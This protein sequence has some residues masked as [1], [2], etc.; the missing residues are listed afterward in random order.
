MIKRDIY[1][2]LNTFRF[3]VLVEIWCYFVSKWNALFNKKVQMMNALLNRTKYEILR[4]FCSNN[5]L[6]AVSR[7]TINYKNESKTLFI[8]VK[9]IFWSPWSLWLNETFPERFHKKTIVLIGI[10]RLFRNSFIMDDKRWI[11]LFIHLFGKLIKW[12]RKLYRKEFDIDTLWVNCLL[13]INP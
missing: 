8:E 2:S 3:F 10:F 5:N 12:P 6:I 9:M 1:P 13:C 11:T 4:F 7:N